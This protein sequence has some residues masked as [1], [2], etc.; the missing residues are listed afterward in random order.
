MNS[1]FRTGVIVNDA[2]KYQPRV[3][4][5]SLTA[6]DL[7][8]PPNCST[9]PVTGLAVYHTAGTSVARNVTNLSRINPAY[10]HGEHKRH[11]LAARGSLQDV[12]WNS[13]NT[14][15]NPIAG[16]HLSLE[17]VTEMSRVGWV[18]K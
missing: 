4:R 3:K 16:N 5:H 15:I 14:K 1:N 12:G 2:R 18:S 11:G 10:M 7:S 8:N 9:C 13:R 6:G 17:D